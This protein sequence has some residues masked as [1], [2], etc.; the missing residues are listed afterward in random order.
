MTETYLSDNDTARF[1]DVRQEK[2]VRKYDRNFV[3]TFKKTRRHGMFPC[4]LANMPCLHVSS[5]LYSPWS[6]RPNSR[7]HAD[8]NYI[9]SKK[10]CKPNEDIIHYLTLFKAFYSFGQIQNNNHYTCITL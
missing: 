10:L 7:E 8:D 6:K 2:S 3:D 1:P 9:S 4:Y 5:G